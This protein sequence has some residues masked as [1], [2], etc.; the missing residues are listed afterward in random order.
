MVTR[1]LLTI[2]SESAFWNTRFL[3]AFKTSRFFDVW[4]RVRA[5]AILTINYLFIIIFFFS[6]EK[7]CVRMWNFKTFYLG[8]PS[9][10]LLG[11]AEKVTRMRGLATC[12]WPCES[13]K[14]KEL[15]PLF[16]NLSFSRSSIGTTLSTIPPASASS[17]LHLFASRIAVR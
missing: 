13:F 5:R 7:C 8:Q 9:L 15:A 2:N 3:F 14:Q 4:T 6:C 1:S 16:F 17:P 12:W 11:L 10:S